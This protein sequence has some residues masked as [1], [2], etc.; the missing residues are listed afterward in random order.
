MDAK[1]SAGPIEQ[2]SEVQVAAHKLLD[3]LRGAFNWNAPLPKNS[4]AERLG[5]ACKALEDALKQET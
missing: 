2:L 1:E 4:H 5:N 3:V